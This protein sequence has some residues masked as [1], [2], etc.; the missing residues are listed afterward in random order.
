MKV[1]SFRAT[2]SGNPVAKSIWVGMCR[3]PSEVGGDKGPTMSTATLE[4]NSII[5]GSYFR[6][7]GFTL[8]LTD[9]R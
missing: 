1:T 4:K 9:M 6:E 2:A 3:C 5:I 7:T 8:P